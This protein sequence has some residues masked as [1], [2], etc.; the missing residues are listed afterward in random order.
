MTNKVRWY[1]IWTVAIPLQWAFV[2]ALILVPDDVGGKL[3]TMMTGLVAINWVAQRLTRRTG[4]SPPADLMF[5]GPVLGSEN[6]DPQQSRACAFLAL[7]EGDYEQAAQHF[8]VLIREDPTDADAYLG[9]GH[10]RL[11][12]RQYDPALK[13]YTIA[14]MLGRSDLKVN[15]LIG[16]GRVYLEQ[17]ELALAIEDF[18]AA[19]QDDPKAAEAFFWRSQAYDKKGES[20]LASADRESAARFTKRQGKRRWLA[21]IKKAWPSRRTKTIRSRRAH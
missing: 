17:G 1:L 4:Y 5:I 10:A 9:R 2:V 20:S 6:E 12:L 8:A 18:N 19:L 14:L 11:S 7:E 13:D 3:I 15:A 21:R 16:R